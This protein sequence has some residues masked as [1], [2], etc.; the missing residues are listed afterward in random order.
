MAVHVINRINLKLLT[1]LTE[2]DCDACISLYMPVEQA[3]PQTRKNSIVF[4]DLCA[5]TEE[6]LKKYGIHEDRIT[7]LLHPLETI[8]ADREFWESRPKGLAFFVSDTR[9]LVYRSRTAFP[10]EAIVDKRFYIRPLLPLAQQQGQVNIALLGRKGARLVK[11]SELQCRYIRPPEELR[12]L[13]NFL[14]HHDFER[15][16]QHAPSRTAPFIHGQNTA[17]DKAVEHHY[18]QDYY[19]AFKNWLQTKIRKGTDLYLAGDDNNTGLF[20]KAA[21]DFPGNITPLI[22]KNIQA[23][24][25]KELLKHVRT[26]LTRHAGQKSA[27]EFER[28]L[29]T[30]STAPERAIENAAGEIVAAAHASK[31]QTL[32]LPPEDEK[33]W[34]H[35]DAA[36]Q[37]IVLQEKPEEDIG[38]ELLNLAA[39]RTLRSGGA[40]FVNGNKNAAAIYHW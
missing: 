22:R 39:I 9:Q 33:I 40:V 31:I 4:K 18:L 7:K 15:S 28:F 14:S 27:E 23:L 2:D 32:F 16:L 1:F 26:A 30:R 36:N 29:Q 12:S 20:M 8:A 38:E 10:V 3:G 37:N 13:E 25:D 21:E 6:K 11:C 34:G 19:R 17:S 35:F 5:R 24:D